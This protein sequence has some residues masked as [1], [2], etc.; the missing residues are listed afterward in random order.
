MEHTPKHLHMASAFAVV[1]SFHT[2]VFSRTAFVQNSDAQMVPDPSPYPPASRGDLVSDPCGVPSS[3]MDSLP[4][5]VYAVAFGMSDGF[6][7][8]GNR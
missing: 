6:R 3:G 1:L 7:H 5:L 2:H 8:L 4:V